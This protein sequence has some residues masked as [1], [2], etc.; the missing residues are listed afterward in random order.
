ME[1]YEKELLELFKQHD[2]LL[3]MVNMNNPSSA[4]STAKISSLAINKDRI[5]KR[6]ALLGKEST[7]PSAPSSKDAQVDMGD[8]ELLQLQDRIINQQDHQ[9]DSLSQVLGR[10][11][12]VHLDHYFDANRNCCRLES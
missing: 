11:K 12:K 2:R 3:H 7:D 10:Q 4:T 5:L 8:G 9:L 6:D 1:K